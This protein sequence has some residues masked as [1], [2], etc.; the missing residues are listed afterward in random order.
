MGL[1]N[2]TGTIIA[3]GY[4][5]HVRVGTNSGGAEEVGLVASFQ[6]TED[7]Q[8]QE[9]V[10]LGHLGPIAIDPQGYTCSITLD[11]FLPAKREIDA[12]QYENSGSAAMTNFVKDV[13]REKLAQDGS[14]TKMEYLDFYNRRGGI[15][16][17]A[18]KGVVL[19][20]YGVTAEANGYVRNNVQLRALEM[21]AK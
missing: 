10:V 16:L 3:M 21:T 13:T 2:L 1:P 19:S 18:F 8:T 4:N 9:A 15:I 6:A 17:A 5:C 20:S 7:F 12:E 11:G 14:I